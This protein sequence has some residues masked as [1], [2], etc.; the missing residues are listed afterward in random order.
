MYV[1]QSNEIS[2]RCPTEKGRL[3]APQREI[4]ESQLITSARS[5]SHAKSKSRSVKSL[6]LLALP[7]SSS[8]LFQYHFTPPIQNSAEIV[9]FELRRRFKRLLAIRDLVRLL[10][11]FSLPITFSRSLEKYPNESNWPP[12]PLRLW[13]SSGHAYQLRTHLNTR[14]TLL[15][16]SSKT[17]EISQT[18]EPQQSPKNAERNGH[19]SVALRNIE[20]EVSERCRSWFFDFPVQ[21][22]IRFHVR[23][24]FSQ[25]QT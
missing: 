25:E 24:S 4:R 1:P 23:C 3:C 8:H 13:N 19:Q 14:G 6:L 20:P 2:S 21:Y 16:T 9:E 12:F 11:V 7:H 17:K 10:N 22:L 15:Q 18:G 5:H